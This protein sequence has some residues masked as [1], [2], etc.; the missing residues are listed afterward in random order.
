M[1]PEPGAIALVPTAAAK[2]GANRL[3]WWKERGQAQADRI[4]CECIFLPIF[5]R[6]DASNIEYITQVKV[7]DSYIFQE[8]TQVI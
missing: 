2:E 6:E 3:Q 5:N 8:E 4:G 1:K 7:Q